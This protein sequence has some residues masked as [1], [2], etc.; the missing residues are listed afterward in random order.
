MENKN[1][2]FYRASSALTLVN[3]FV[4]FFLTVALLIVVFYD[5]QYFLA[6]M[7]ITLFVLITALDVFTIYLLKNNEIETLPFSIKI[8][9]SVALIILSFILPG[10][11][12]LIPTI[13]DKKKNP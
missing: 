6:L 10:V 2:K 12:I 13:R 1:L 11:L 8:M 9:L 3:I 4:K 7:M 5:R